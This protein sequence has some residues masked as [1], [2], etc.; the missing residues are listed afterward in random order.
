MFDKS[1]NKQAT[2]AAYVQFAQPL[3]GFVLR[4]LGKPPGSG[5][6]DDVV[7][8][9][10]ADLQRKGTFLLNEAFRPAPDDPAA[11]NRKFKFLCTTAIRKIGEIRKKTSGKETGNVVEDEPAVPAGDWPDVRAEQKEE[12]GRLHAALTAMDPKL[13]EVVVPFYFS[14]LS[15]KEIAVALNLPMGT[16]GTRLVR[17]RAALRLALGQRS[18]DPPP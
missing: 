17:A 7:Q 11:A 1:E 14:D 18:T 13:R 4:C 6:G 16:V 5:A 12:I 15:I 10:F 9:V 8:E 2:E 3:T